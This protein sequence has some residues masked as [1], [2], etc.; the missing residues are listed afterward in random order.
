MKEQ[1]QNT[2][3]RD[4]LKECSLASIPFL[5][6]T[7]GSDARFENY[8]SKNMENKQ[9][10]INF[11]TA[12]LN[13]SPSEYLDKLSEI[14]AV[15]KIEIDFYGHGGATT[16]LEKKFAQLTGKEKAIYLPTGT[17]ANQLAIKLLSGNNTK[18]IVPEN[19]HIFRD[20]ADA[21]Q[22]IHHKRLIPLGKDKPYFELDDLENSIDYLNKNEAFQ[23]GFG[24]LAIES[25]VRRASGVAIPFETLK[26][27]SS[28]CKKNGYKTHLDGA[29]IHVASAY[30]G[31]SLME[32][33]TLF[34]TVYISLYKY[35]NAS[36]G[37]I[38]CGDAA[39]IDQVPHLIKILGG[40]VFQSWQNTAVALHHLEGIEDRWEQVVKTSTKLI[41]EL[42]KIDGISISNIKN[43]TNIYDL[44]ISDSIDP[45]VMVKFLSEN[46]NILV[47]HANENNI[48]KF[49]VN[50]SILRR[51]FDDILSTMKSGIDKARK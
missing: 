8:K 23:S 46:H 4:F 10:K 39:I 37:A 33:S 17:M 34:D 7:V 30:T 12:G 43:G 24:M 25:P 13:L 41:A 51:Y 28:Y 1:K 49:A 19:S 18:A 50:E 45:K 21:A 15:Q 27:I 38:L 5:I 6:P 32:Y 3:R 14:N 48:A 22:S 11:L 9:K 2:K 47:R 20:E 29:R 16:L 40:N 31:V 44:Q 36:G 35:L 42:N 26:K